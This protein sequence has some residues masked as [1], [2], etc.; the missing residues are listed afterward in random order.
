MK[1]EHPNIDH[2]QPW[3]SADEYETPPCPISLFV[4][5]TARFRYATEEERLKYTPAHEGGPVA[6]AWVEDLVII[7]QTNEDGTDLIV[8]NPQEHWWIF[9]LGNYDHFG[10]GDCGIGY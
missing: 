9:E 5:I 2:C 1:N 4:A 3:G 7:C 10:V 6:I 8:Q